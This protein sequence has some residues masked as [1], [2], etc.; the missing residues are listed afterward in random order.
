MSQSYGAKL[1]VS[2]IPKN[3]TWFALKDFIAL[4]AN[5]IKHVTVSQSR[6]SVEFESSELANEAMEALASQKYEGQQLEI[7]KYVPV[8][9]VRNPKKGVTV[10][11]LSPLSDWRDLK[12]ELSVHGAIRYA[13][14][15][16]VGVYR[17]F[18]Y[19]ITI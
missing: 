10:R 3:M 1:I 15:V 14:V 8:V 13:D 17:S 19:L 2:N 16:K 7:R 12:D 4:H 9:N 5:G 11:G 6:G 18:S